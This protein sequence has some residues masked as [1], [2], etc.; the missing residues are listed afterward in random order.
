MSGSSEPALTPIRI[1]SPR[2]FASRATTLMCSALRMLPGLSRS[3]WTP[4]SIAASASL[5]WKWMSAMIG[6]GERG[7]I[8]AN[9]SAAASSL[10]VQRTMSHPAAASE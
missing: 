7:T 8:C 9:P 6:T 3:P 2:S 5:Y 1:G 4:A 10:Q